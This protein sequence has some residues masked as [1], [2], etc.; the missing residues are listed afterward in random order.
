MDTYKSGTA[1]TTVFSLAAG[2]GVLAP[3]ALRARVH[4]EEGNLIADWAAVALPEAGADSVAVATAAPQNTLVPPQLRG[5]RVVELEVV[6]TAGTTYLEAAH[7]LESSQLLVPGINS[8]QTYYQAVLEAQLYTDETMSGWAAQTDQ[9]VRQRALSEAFE[10]IRMM[11]VVIEWQNDQTIIRSIFNDPPR[12]RDLDS[13][14]I[15]RLD[16]RLMK[17]L[18][19]AQLVEANDI[20]VADP[21]QALRRAGIQS[22]TV[23]ESSNY[24]GAT[25]PFDYGGV[26]AETRRVLARWVRSRTRIGRA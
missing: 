15:M 16:T 3:T 10:R 1:V 13:A 7:V 20:L 18:K 2:D 14:Q 26:C 23:G 8:F 22:Q 19:K 25:R 11:P 4:D 12:L 24:F 9:A 6:D 17:A 5:V 21:L